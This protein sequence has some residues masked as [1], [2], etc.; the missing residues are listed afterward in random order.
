MAG[1]GGACPDWSA[2]YPADNDYK[3]NSSVGAAGRGKA[4]RRVGVIGTRY[5]CEKCP[6]CERGGGLPPR[7]ATQAGE[8]PGLASQSCFH[9]SASA[10]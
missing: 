8:V 1:Q 4:G 5:P 10:G 6:T 2:S 3:N 7:L 9:F